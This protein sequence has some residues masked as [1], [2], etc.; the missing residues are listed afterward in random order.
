MTEQSSFTVLGALFSVRV[1]V[2]VRFSVPGSCS[3]FAREPAGRVENVNLKPEPNMNFE[4][5]TERE[6][7]HEP[8]TENLEA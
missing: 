5:R 2:Q 7:E 4:P 3:G 8:S 6:H 1:Q